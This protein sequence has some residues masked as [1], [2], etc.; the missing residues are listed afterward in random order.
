MVPLDADEIEAEL[1][2]F[3]PQQPPPLR[4]KEQQ[5]QQQNQQQLGFGWSAQDDEQPG[6]GP[7]GAF[8]QLLSPLRGLKAWLDHHHGSYSQELEAAALVA[9]KDAETAA[10]AAAAASSSDAASKRSS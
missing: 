9:V 5:N 2:L 3:S 4:N 7:G 10:A 8:V 1:S 6:S